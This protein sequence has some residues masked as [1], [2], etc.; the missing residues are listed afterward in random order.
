MKLRSRAVA[1]CAAVAATTSTVPALAAPATPIEHV[2]VIYSENISF[3]H[4]FATYPNALN[5]DGEKLQSS[6]KDAPKFEA[7]E[8]TPKVN[9]LENNDLLG[10]KN[11]NS[12][13][14]FRLTPEQAVTADQN[15]HYA[16]EQKAYNGGKM[17]KFSETVSVDNDKYDPQSYGTT[18]LTMGYY[19]GNTV[20]GMWN[21]AQN[22]AMNDNSFSTIF[23]PSTP[24]ALNLI[25]G[26]VAGATMHD[27]A[28]GEQQ[29]I[30]DGENH[31]LAGVSEDGK[32]ATVVGD[33]D[34][35]YD[36]LSLIHI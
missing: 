22:F 10:D 23:G 33:P 2:V 26:T 8:G 25:A 34:P 31:A 17:D 13:K 19:D 3:D 24:G 35:L 5:K 15:H 29:T 20:T 7:K 12:T 30:K 16:D 36:D 27:P 18:G 6:E 14:P 1:L 9:N 11:P 21:Y 4:Y 32:T 28:T